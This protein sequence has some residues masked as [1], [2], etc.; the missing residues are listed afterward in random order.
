M[1]RVSSPPPVRARVLLLS[2]ADFETLTTFRRTFATAQMAGRRINIDI[3][4]DT[5]RC[6]RGF[7]G[8][9]RPEARG[10]ITRLQ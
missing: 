7:E 8:R 4:S 10:G 6:R 1:L 2:L 3:V 9:F 5:V